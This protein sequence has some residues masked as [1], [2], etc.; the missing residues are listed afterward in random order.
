MSKQILHKLHAVSGGN[1]IVYNAELAKAIG[2]VEAALI[3]CHIAFW[4]GLGSRGDWVYKT[5]K[6]LQQDTGLTKT[7]QLT[8]I[9]KCTSLG[10]LICEYKSVPRTRHFKVSIEKLELLFPS[11]Q[12]TRPLNGRNK[13]AQSFGKRP[14][15]TEKN[16]EITTKNS[17]LLKE[18]IGLLAERKKM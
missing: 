4:Q 16:P 3:V 18:A 5:V 10:I 12:E 2:S 6:Q 9:K 7:Q 17:R 1:P 11:R 15:I 13:P 14:P 8:A